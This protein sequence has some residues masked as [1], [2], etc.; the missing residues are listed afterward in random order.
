M[1]CE[2]NNFKPRQTCCPF[3]NGFEWCIIAEG[4]NP[5]LFQRNGKVPHLNQFN[6]EGSKCEVPTN[7][8]MLL[9]FQEVLLGSCL[10][11]NGNVVRSDKTLLEILEEA[12]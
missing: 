1:K 8:K 3:Y 11:K 5:W 6:N 12:R 4:T 9:G 7:K 2:N 10:D